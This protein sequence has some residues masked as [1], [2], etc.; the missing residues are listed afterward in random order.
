MA[1]RYVRIYEGPT[2]DIDIIGGSASATGAVYDERVHEL[3]RARGHEMRILDE[4]GHFTPENSRSC[5]H[6]EISPPLS[7][8]TIYA[9][10]GLLAGSEIVDPYHNEAFLIDNRLSST[11]PNRIM[12][13]W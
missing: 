9:L 8:E 5:C 7:D 1:N 13:R 12:R 4:P 11:P 2:L 10:G 6:L 3:L